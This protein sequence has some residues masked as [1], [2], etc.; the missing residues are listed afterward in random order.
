MSPGP[1][2]W[3]WGSNRYICSHTTLCWRYCMICRAGCYLPFSRDED[4]SEPRGEEV[5]GNWPFVQAF[6]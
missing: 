4:V 6:T 1:K 3:T 2:L 5:L